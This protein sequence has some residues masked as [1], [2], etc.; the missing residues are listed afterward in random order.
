MENN[1]KGKVVLER[2]Q[3]PRRDDVLGSERTHP[4]M[5][6]FPLGTRGKHQKKIWK[7]IIRD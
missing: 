5:L 7:V 6:T 2:N 4:R 3:V 1:G